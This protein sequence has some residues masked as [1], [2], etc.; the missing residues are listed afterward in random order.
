MSSEKK[1]ESRLRGLPRL[2]RNIIESLILRAY[3]TSLIAL[4]L[5]LSYLAFRYLI[6]A[7]L[8]PPP[9]S[10]VL[11]ASSGRAPTEALGVTRR[12]LAPGQAMRLPHARLSHHH[13]LDYW[14]Q[15]DIGNNCTT[16]GCHAPLPHARA[17][18]TRAFL[19][20]HATSIH[21]GV[22]HMQSQ[23]QPLRAAWYDVQTG[24]EASA[25]AVLLA[26][27]LIQQSHD[28]A[29]RTAEFRRALLDHLRQ[30]YVESDKNPE[31]GFLIEHLDA[32]DESSVAFRDLV[33]HSAVLLPRH[34]RGEYGR[35]IALVDPDTGGPL[36]RHPNTDAAILR[37]LGSATELSG[38]RRKEALAAIH[39]LRREVPLQC[40]DCHVRDSSQLDFAA[41]QYGPSRVD[42]LTASIVFTMIQH[43]AEGR[44]FHLPQLLDAKNAPQ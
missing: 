34:F 31:L 8:V 36:L 33:R 2:A 28:D 5:G 41:L 26:Y 4:I 22:C 44:P 3:A 25:P 23:D 42:A 21:C 9:P 20:M 11:A 29:R 7:L 6:V 12:N 43:I 17:K 15:D 18:E 14:T 27:N 35:K 1:P 24:R 10:T 30:A 16:S 32:L 37:F 39:P 40:R 19:N 13:R 38:S